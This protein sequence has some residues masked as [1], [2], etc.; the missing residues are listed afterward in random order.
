MNSLKKR[1]KTKKCYVKISQLKRNALKKGRE[2]VK[3]R[4]RRSRA[5][6]KALI[7]K[8]HEENES[9][10][11]VDTDRNF[12]PMMVSQQF[13]KGGEASR[14]R[15][16]R[17]DDRLHKKEKQQLSRKCDSLGKK[18][19]RSSSTVKI[20]SPLTPKRKTMKMMKNAGINPCNTSEIQKQL[21]F[22]ETISKGIQEA[23]NEKK[24][25]KES[26]RTMASGKILKKYRLLRYAANKTNTDRRKL[27]KANGKVMNPIKP[28]KGFEPVLHKKVL[29]F[30]HRDDVST[31]LPGKRDT[32]KVKRKRKLVQKRV[33]NDY[34]HN[35]Y[36]SL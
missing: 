12:S 23:V 11:T 1:E 21:L 36:Q 10:A 8:I 26:I 22:T 31:A 29:D 2:A 3:E 20:N 13:P 27:S 35:L 5:Q 18:L 16:R 17:S 9:C 33:L 6:K 14:K 28:K 15:K 30:Y 25:K 4:V 19:T 24:N 34:L 32:K 7:E